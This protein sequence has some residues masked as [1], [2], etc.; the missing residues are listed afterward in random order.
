[1]NSNWE[2]HAYTTADRAIIIWEIMWRT[3]FGPEPHQI[4]LLKLLND[5]VFLTAYPLHDGY[6]EPWK[7]QLPT[8]RQVCNNS[9]RFA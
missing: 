3:K 4:G 5:E 9:Y 2:K 8:H 7:N 1:M 6:V